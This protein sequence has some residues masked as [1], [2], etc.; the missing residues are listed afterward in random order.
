MVRIVCMII[1]ILLLLVVCALCE[2]K[3]E[4]L[5]FKIRRYE[6][7]HPDFSRLDSEKKMVLLADL[8]NKVY[9][10]KNDILLEK[11]RKEAPDVIFVAGDMLVGRPKVELK[12]AQDFLCKLPAICPVYYGLGNHEQRIKLY[13]EI[14]GE[15]VYL[16]Y[17]ERLKKAGI[18]FLENER[19]TLQLDRLKVDIAGLELP[20]SVYHRFRPSQL[21]VEEIEKSI[22]KSSDDFQILLAHNPVDFS[23]YKEWG[24]DLTLSGHLHGGIIRIP[25]IGGLVTPQAI[26]FPKYSGEMTVEENQAIIVSRGLG[27]HTINYRIFNP[28]E[29]VSIT[30]F[31]YTNKEKDTKDNKYNGNHLGEKIWEYQ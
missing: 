28:A 19:I 26:L 5:F 3:R 29:V 15:G 11:I 20:M 6:F 18:I 12:E 23:A 21:S 17:R 8:H 31:P 2:G 4:L 27:T 22:G 24:A 14:Y 13:P 10:E 30:L 25:F 7:T 9:G 1:G 16:Q